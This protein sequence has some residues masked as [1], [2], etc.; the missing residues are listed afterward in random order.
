MKHNYYLLSRKAFRE[1]GIEFKRDLTSPM[2]CPQVWQM[3]EN[4]YN[5]EEMETPAADGAGDN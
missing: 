1:V 2:I 5:D 3:A 4:I